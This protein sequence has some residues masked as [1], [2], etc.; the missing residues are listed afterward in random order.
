MTSNE[1]YKKYIIRMVN[2]INENHD[3]SQIY[4][5]VH[6]KYIKEKSRN[7]CSDQDILPDATGARADS[8]ASAPG[9]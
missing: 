4:T 8:Q 1:T 5:I 9:H 3:L 7:E 6:K 2:Q